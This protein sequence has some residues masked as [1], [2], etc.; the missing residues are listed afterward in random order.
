VGALRLAE[1]PEGGR[2]P[3]KKNIGST[4]RLI[5]FVIAGLLIGLT[6]LTKNWIFGVL[7]AYPL[8]T[9]ILQVC[10]AKEAMQFNP[11]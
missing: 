3:V 1:F 10:P 5:R 7:A 2:K 11:R 9:A 4:D 8:V 6:V